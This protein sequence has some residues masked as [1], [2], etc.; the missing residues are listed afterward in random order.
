ME[1]SKLE[2]LIYRKRF[3]EEEQKRLYKELRNI[4]DQFI[5]VKKQI[6]EYKS[7]LEPT[8]E[9]IC[10]IEF[11]PST[12]MGGEYKKLRG[13]IEKNHKYIYI[14][15]MNIDTNQVGFSISKYTETNK[16][17]N[18][19]EYLLTLIRPN[20]EGR[21]IIDIN[22]KY[23]GKN[24]YFKIVDGIEVYKIIWKGNKQLIEKFNSVK[25]CLDYIYKEIV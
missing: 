21:K 9:S 18:E 4:D 2:W 3:L 22:D 5:E 24:G 1:H 11:W 8:L 20:K 14:S 15:G 25:E 13:Y 12:A 17:V 16:Y 19:F 23:N 10:A 7:G 6:S